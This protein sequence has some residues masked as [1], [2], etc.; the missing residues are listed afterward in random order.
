MMSNVRANGHDDRRQGVTLGIEQ[1]DAV[2][3][4]IAGAEAQTAKHSIETEESKPKNA[5]LKR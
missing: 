5:M 4:L 3:R 2:H 1:S